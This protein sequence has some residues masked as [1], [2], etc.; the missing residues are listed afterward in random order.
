MR[1]FL[2]G[3]Y[4]SPCIIEKVEGQGAPAYQALTGKLD[5]PLGKSGFCTSASGAGSARMSGPTLFPGA[6]PAALPFI[7]KFCFRVADQKFTVPQANAA[8]R[9]VRQEYR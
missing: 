1:K 3:N 6:Y 9:D 8:K 5:Y 4:Q 7:K 2:L